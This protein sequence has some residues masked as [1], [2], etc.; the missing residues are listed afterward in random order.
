VGYTIETSEIK[1]SNHGVK[2]KSL[3][4]I[5][6]QNEVNCRVQPNV[7]APVV[8]RVEA[9]CPE[10]ADTMKQREAALQL[11]QS[12]ADD[13][14]E[15]N[16][17]GERARRMSEANERGER[18]RRMSDANERG[19]AGE[20]KTKRNEAPK[21]QQRR[22]ERK[23]K[24]VCDELTDEEQTERPEVRTAVFNRS[25]SGMR[26]EAETV[27]RNGQKFPKQRRS[28]RSSRCRAVNNIIKLLHNVGV[29]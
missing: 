7:P 25:C 15:A 4:Q 2:T 24:A 18:A 12:E 6:G 11:G 27:Q 1:V 26:P 23:Q 22:S 9:G 29:L 20:R 28:A 19:E 8:K 13:W 10:D 16:E 14:S 3:L 17:R 21:P 5:V